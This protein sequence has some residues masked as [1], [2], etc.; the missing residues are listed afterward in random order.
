MNR[1]CTSIQEEKDYGK[2]TALLHEMSELS[3]RKEQRRFQQYPN[4]Y[5]KGIDLGKRFP[6]W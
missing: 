3:A 2:F 1:L 4:W 6:L 5:G